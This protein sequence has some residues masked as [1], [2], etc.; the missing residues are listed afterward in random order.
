M[1]RIEGGRSQAALSELQ[2]SELS[3]APISPWSQ[4]FLKCPDL[5]VFKISKLR[6]LSELP[7]A[8]EPSR[9]SELSELP[10]LPELSEL[11]KPSSGLEF[12]AQHE[13]DAARSAGAGRA[14]VQDARDLAKAGLW[15][16]RTPGKRAQG[17]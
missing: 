12:E 17:A 14:I 6:E 13:L 3:G 7:E 16:R 2:I 9:L 5:P 4:N 8:S 1:T 15:F 11:S 10:K